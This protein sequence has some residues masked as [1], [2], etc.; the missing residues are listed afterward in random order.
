MIKK[1]KVDDIICPC[2]EQTQHIVE[3]TTRGEIVCTNCGY[4]IHLECQYVAGYKV[5]NNDTQFKIIKD[6]RKKKDKKKMIIEN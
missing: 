1:R 2:C 6:K 4:I 5:T 3:D